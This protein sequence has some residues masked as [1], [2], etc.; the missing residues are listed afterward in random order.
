MSAAQPPSKLPPVLWVLLGLPFVA[1]GIFVAIWLFLSPSPSNVKLVAFTD[2]V[3]E[4][5]AGRVREIHVRGQTIHFV[6]RGE[7]GSHLTEETIGPADAALIT[8][9]RPT[10]PSLPAPRVSFEK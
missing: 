2:F 3:D 10:D 7:N 5:H 4:V 1:V 9:L 6:V 8:S